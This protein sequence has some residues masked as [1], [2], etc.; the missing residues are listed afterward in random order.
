MIAICLGITTPWVAQNELRTIVARV[1][2]GHIAELSAQA[3]RRVYWQFDLILAEIPP[4]QE[5]L[6]N[7][8]I[9]T[10]SAWMMLLIPSNGPWQNSSV[11][12]G[13]LKR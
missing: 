5:L 11:L 8:Y 7:Q 9:C 3:G 6:V 12:S 13:S 1:A 2:C 4:T 10:P